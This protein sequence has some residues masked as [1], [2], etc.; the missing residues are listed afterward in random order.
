MTRTLCDWCRK[1]NISCPL[2]PDITRGTCVEF[3][4][5]NEDSREEAALHY[6]D[7]SWGQQGSRHHYQQLV[8]ILSQ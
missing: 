4:A 5:A 6:A 2:E 3:R 1:F 8:R 7:L